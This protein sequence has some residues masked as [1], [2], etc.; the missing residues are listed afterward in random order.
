LFS[1]VLSVVSG[2]GKVNVTTVVFL[3][4]VAKSALALNSK[5]VFGVIAARTDYQV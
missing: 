4:E 1:L 5:V 2:Y 3:L